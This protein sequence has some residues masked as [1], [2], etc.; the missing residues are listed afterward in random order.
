MRACEREI[1]E[2]YLLFRRERQAVKITCRILSDA[3]WIG[4]DTLM[5]RYAR[6]SAVLQHLRKSLTLYCANGAAPFS[7]RK[8]K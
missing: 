6:L 7:W 4:M 2:K 3:D 1:I 8:Y 5:Y